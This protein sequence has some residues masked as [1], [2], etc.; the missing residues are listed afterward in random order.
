MALVIVA[1]RLSRGRYPD[2]PL[3][4]PD[5]LGATEQIVARFKLGLAE[6]SQLRNELLL[7]S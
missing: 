6:F 7:Y 2:L 3:M 5:P 1:P 4:L